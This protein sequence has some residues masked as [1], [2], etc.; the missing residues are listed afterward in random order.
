M[1]IKGGGVCVR[2]GTSVK[3]CSSERCTK[4]QEEYRDMGQVSSDAVV[5]DV[6][7][8]CS[9]TRKRPEAVIGSSLVE[10]PSHAVITMSAVKV[11]ADTGLSAETM[12]GDA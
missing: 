10:I 11:A 4:R 12:A 9:A 2:H 7:V 6:Q 8:T 5:K 1:V 3:R